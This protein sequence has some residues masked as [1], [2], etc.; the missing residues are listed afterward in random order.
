MG[1]RAVQIVGRPSS[2]PSSE[3]KNRHAI[4][5]LDRA[6]VTLH[7]ATPPRRR[8]PCGVMYFEGATKREPEH[9]SYSAMSKCG[10]N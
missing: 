3:G 4:V 1:A 10:C 8:N 5:Q 7:D 2:V 6:A 9:W